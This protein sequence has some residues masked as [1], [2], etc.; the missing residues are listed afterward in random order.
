PEKILAQNDITMIAAILRDADE[1]TESAAPWARRIRDR[2]HHRM[3]HDTGEDASAMDLRNSNKVYE[4]LQSKFNGIDFYWD[5]P[6]RPVAIHKLLI[7]EDAEE[8][9]KVVLR[10]I[11]PRGEIDYVGDRSHILRRVP[12]QF[13]VARIFC[14]LGGEQEA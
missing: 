11:G 13:Q 12:R 10:L 8:K 14:D 1:G 2:R 3:V 4:L 6:N 5:K 9:G 7:P